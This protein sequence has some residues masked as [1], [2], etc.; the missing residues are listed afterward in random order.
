MR[1]RII[2]NTD[3]FHTV[4]ELLEILFELHKV[5]QFVYVKHTFCYTS[6]IKS[7]RADYLCPLLSVTLYWIIGE[8]F[9]LL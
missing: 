9:L 3:T 7:W 4:M 8:A 1:T 6:L 2:L 5:F